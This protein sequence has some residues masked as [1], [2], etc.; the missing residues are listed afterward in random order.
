MLTSLNTLQRNINIS[1]MYLYILTPMIMVYALCVSRE[2]TTTSDYYDG[3]N[4]YDN[5]NYTDG[6]YFYDDD[7]FPDDNYYYDNILAQY[8]FLDEICTTQYSCKSAYQYCR[9]DAICNV[10]QDCCHDANISDANTT[11]LKLEEIFPY[12]ECLYF[13]EVHADWFI[14]V[15]NSCPIDAKNSLKDL[16]ENIDIGNV[17]SSTPVFGNTSLFLY[18]NLYCAV[19]HNEQYTFLYPKLSCSWESEY[20][21]NYTIKELLQLNACN[22]EYTIAE[23]FNMFHTSPVRECY[24]AITECSNASADDIHKRECKTRRNEY[25]FTKNNIYTN[26]HCY[27]CS[28]EIGSDVTCINLIYNLSLEE[29]K[30]VHAYSYRILF[31]LES[32]RARS[33]KILGHFHKENY[34]FSI[35]SKCL[36]TQILDPFT[37]TCRDIACTSE[38]YQRKFRCENATT[39]TF[40]NG[41]CTSIEF[42]DGE[43]ERLNDTSIFVYNSNKTYYDVLFDGSIAHVC[44]KVRTSDQFVYRN[45]PI[46]GWLSFVSG[47]VSI[48]CLCFTT[49][50]YMLPKLQNQ[51]G[52]LLIC[53]SISLCLAQLLFFVARKA[54]N[55]YVLCKTLG[56]LVHFFFL[57]SFLW[58]NAMSFNVFKTF[59][60]SF[61]NVKNNR[62]HFVFYSLYVWLSSLIIISVGILLDEMTSWSYRPKYG[63]STCWISNSN[64]LMVFLLIPL[65]VVVLLNSVFFA[66]SVRSICVTKLKSSELLQ[67]K[68]NCEIFIYIK[69][70]TVMGLTWV[71]G[72]IATWVQNQVFWYL[73]VIFNGL[74]GLFIFCSFVLNRRVYLVVRECFKLRTPIGKKHMKSSDNQAKPDISVP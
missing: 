18:R 56:I 49:I 71:C 15:V 5:D 48:A 42:D 66:L 27:L 29:G 7:F 23:D 57:A 47:I 4:Y 24:P 72:Y 59:S 21:G 67:T 58:M 37:D 2:Q 12:A 3:L 31:D 30:T 50:V 45:D 73:F 51:P 13:P 35:G 33:E 10:F 43:Y 8:S 28:Y 69:L 65:A 55:D 41:T 1:V 25:V 54:E 61:S 64:G 6:D 63:V 11:N 17:I 46:E 52:R 44:I 26:K 14:F 74:Q 70:S 19:C 16:C 22:I 60:A 38:A 53:L 20:R 40:R 36:N 9:C 62:K 68:R 34:E 32:G 39:K